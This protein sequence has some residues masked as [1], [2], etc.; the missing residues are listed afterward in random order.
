MAAL[1]DMYRDF[2]PAT[3]DVISPEKCERELDRRHQAR[4]D[5]LGDARVAPASERTSAR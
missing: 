5:P 3:L 4:A 2:D 1:A